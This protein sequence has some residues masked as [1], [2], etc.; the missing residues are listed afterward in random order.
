M[1]KEIARL[2][3]RIGR[4]TTVLDLEGVQVLVDDG[5]PVDASSHRVT[6]SSPERVRVMLVNPGRRRLVFKLQGYA[7]TAQDVTVNGGEDVRLRVTAPSRD[8]KEDNPHRTPMWIGWTLVASAITGA[9]ISAVAAADSPHGFTGTAGHTSLILGAVGLVA[10][11]AATYFT[12]RTLTWRPSSDVAVT[13]TCSASAAGSERS[14]SSRGHEDPVHVG[15]ALAFVRFALRA[16]GEALALLEAL[17]RRVSLPARAHVR[18]GLRARIPGRGHGIPLSP[19]IDEDSA[20]RATLDAV[21]RVRQ[22]PSHGEATRAT[23]TC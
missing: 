5:C 20:P 21:A 15:L 14:R 4:I 7:E 1:E 16:T 12:I 11:S 13:R 18:A 23:R 19:N 2:R 17:L 10:A 3:P 6:C 8:T 22:S 9:T